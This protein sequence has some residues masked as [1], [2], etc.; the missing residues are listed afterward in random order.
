MMRTNIFYINQNLYTMKKIY[1]LLLIIGCVLISSSVFSREV[2]IIKQ[3]GQRQ[4][5][6]FWKV[7]YKTVS[8]TQTDG[9]LW[10]LACY[11][12]GSETCKK[13]GVLGNSIIIDKHEY[14]EV[15]FNE[16]LNEIMDIVDESIFN[17]KTDGTVGKKIATKTIDGKDKIL[18]FSASWKNA[19]AKTGDV[20]YSIIINELEF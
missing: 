19:D 16:V 3:G 1:F 10:T 14:S 13:S 17:G 9:N 6:T 4:V 20:Q 11:G 12:E 5:I 15:L 7:T 2:Q 8:F 18:A